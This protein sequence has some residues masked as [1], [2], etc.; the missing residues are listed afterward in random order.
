MDVGQRL[1]AWHG[2]DWHTPKG[3]LIRDVVYAMDTG[4]TCTV[5]FIDSDV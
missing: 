4:L 1:K 3:K 5:A 2:E